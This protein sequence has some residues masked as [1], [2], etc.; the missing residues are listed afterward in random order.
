MN[1][2]SCGY[3]LALWAF[4]SFCNCNIYAD[5]AP[6]TLIC[7][8][9]HVPTPLQVQMIRAT[10]VELGRRVHVALRTQ[11][12]DAARLNVQQIECFQML[13]YVEQVCRLNI[14]RSNSI[15]HPF[16]VKHSALLDP[17]EWEVIQTSV[18]DMLQCLDKAATQSLDPANGPPIT[19][20]HLVHTG[21]ARRPSIYIPRDV[22]A[23][24]LQYRGPTHLAPIFNCCPRT[25]RC[26]ALDY[27]LVEPGPPVYVKY[28]HDDGLSY[29]F[30][31]SSTGPVSDLSDDELNTL[32]A[33]IVQRFPNFGRCMIDGHLKHLGHRVPCS[34]VQAA[35]LRVHGPPAASFGRT[36]I[37]RQVY[38][39]PGPNSLWH[40]DGQHGKL[41]FIGLSTRSS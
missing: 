22:L 18:Y 16:Y 28:I 40:H 38:L 36:Q 14:A 27:G 11:V 12:G 30:Y 31:T 10:Y 15:A 39:V 3:F 29:R 6:W 20:S 19:A 41:L 9:Q 13:R 5:L 8:D 37:E 34:R 33:E 32:I 17:T 4:F 2:P 24:A 1:I 26:I 35:Y 25:I 23:A 7:M 21:Q